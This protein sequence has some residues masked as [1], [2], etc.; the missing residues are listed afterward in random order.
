MKQTKAMK[1]D[2]L[3][4]VVTTFPNIVWFDGSQEALLKH[5]YTKNKPQLDK[6]IFEGHE[7]LCDTP[8]ML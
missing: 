8:C 3:R 4:S 2:D 6:N 1:V 7:L 5:G